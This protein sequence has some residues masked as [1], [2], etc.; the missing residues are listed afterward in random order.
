MSSERQLT[1]LICTHNRVELLTRVL[2]SLN[3]A[4]RPDDWALELLVA[5]NACSD[6][7]HS[8]LEDY[9]QRQ[10][11]SHLLPLKWFPEP[12]PGKSNALN[13]AIPRLRGRLVAFVDDDHRV[14]E[15]YLTEICR[16]ADAYPDAT[17]LCGKIL[18]DWDG[19]EPPWVHDEGPYRIYPLPVPRYDQGEDSKPILIEPGPLPGGG[20]LALHV[21]VFE[22]I[23]GFST[24]LGPK[25]HDLGGGEDSAFVLNAL[26]SGERLQYVPD[27]VQHHYVDTERLQFS[28]LMRKAYQRSRSVSRVHHG[29]AGVPRY[30]WRKLVE[31]GLQAA[32]PLTWPRTRFYL[33]RLASTLGEIRGQHEARRL[34][35]RHHSAETATSPRTGRI[36]AISW[37]AIWA[38]GLVQLA[39]AVSQEAV[40]ATLIAMVTVTTLLSAALALKSFLDFSQTGPKVREEILAHYRNYSILAFIR[41]SAYAFV[42]IFAQ[43]ASGALLYGAAMKAFE[44]PV[45]VWVSALAGVIAVTLITGLQFCRHLLHLPAS[46][47]TSSHYRMSRFYPLW[48]QLT[49]MRLSTI[50]TTLLGL[51]LALILMFAYAIAV[52]G[53][54]L[55]LVS[56][57]VM[58][59][60]TAALY[61]QLR[62]PG[63]PDPVPAKKTSARPNVVMIGC[64]TL[65]ADR[66]TP[67]LAPSIEKLA[68]N[69]THFTHCYTPCARTAPSLISLLT[70]TWPHK[71][72]IRDNFVADDDTELNV[73]SLPKLLKDRGYSTAALS[74]WCGSDLRKFSF[75]FEHTDVPDDQWNLKYFIRQGPKD[76]RLFLSLFT[77]NTFGK[78][79][80]PEIH[81]L[82]GVPMTDELG[83]ESCR[84]INKLANNGNPF[85][86]NVFFSTTHPPFGSEYPYY[87]KYSSPEYAGESKF[88]MAR[89]TD[90]WE[91]LRR[92]AEPREAFDLDQ[93][94]HLYDGCVR[95][96]DDEVAR[97]VS[98]LN[99]CGIADNTIV[100]IYSD[101]GMEFFEHDTWGQG[102]SAVGDH[103]PRIPLIVLDPR[104][105]GS[106]RIG[107]VVR[108]IDVAPTI[109][110]LLDLPRPAD[111]DGTSLAPYI[112]NAHADLQLDAYNETGIWMAEMPGMDPDHLRYPNLL[113]MLEV[114]DKTTGTLAIKPEFAT[115]IIAAK[116][117]MLRVGRWKLVYQPMTHGYK[118]SLYDVTTDPGCIHD[119][120]AENQSVTRELWVRLS[121]IM[122]TDSARTKYADAPAPAECH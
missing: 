84:L 108:S 114:P 67:E 33:M 56:L 18:P 122:N 74:D 5:A 103:S 60:A 6:G 78:L 118:V 31:Y 37:A 106:G 13:S 62:A 21:D 96:F 23:G 57:I 46:L 86:F 9:V 43:T 4:R 91:I 32:I 63:Y 66:I 98:H 101:H 79:F 58:G 53:N 85:L 112:R 65:R 34:S 117:R 89:L 68:R 22:R 19:T 100:V 99:D 73:P 44:Q 93:I 121:N 49:P 83:A 81:Y 111:M 39:A 29:T 47:A 77:H 12:V 35:T 61:N 95:R 3:E 14:D 87:T 105:I 15:A 11:S 119:V 90:P 82:G 92:Q 36:Q 59:A 8:M 115:R 97:I 70:G 64:D 1:V 113:E 107:D 48:R 76:L 69:S 45:N 40:L 72:G 24:D 116:D 94:I 50:S 2:A 88:A 38:A 26:S 120:S 30:M 104:K 52:E 75:G 10:P 102:N 25:G 80:L 55:G 17:L 16:A 28:Y 41:V 20:N 27:I 110:D 42:I 51:S 54:F 7:T 71:H 109:L